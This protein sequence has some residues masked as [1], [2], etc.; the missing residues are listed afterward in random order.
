MELIEDAGLGSNSLENVPGQFASMDL[1]G[2]DLL[3]NSVLSG[4]EA[5]I[6]KKEVS[7]L[8]G[9]CCWVEKFSTAPEGKHF[10]FIC[11]PTL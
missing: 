8:R 9:E 2:I 3:V 1:D 11:Y 6:K 5:W 4:V 10:I 7:E